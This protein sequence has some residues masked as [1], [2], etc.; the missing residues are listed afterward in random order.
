MPQLYEPIDTLN[1]PYDAFWA[2]SRNVNDPPRTH[3]HYYIELIYVEDGTLQADYDRRRTILHPGDLAVFYPKQIHTLTPDAAHSYRYGVIKFDIGRLTQSSVYTPKLRT[4]LE[5]AK[6]TP[7]ILPVVSADE[8]SPG[9]AGNAF[10]TVI[11]ELGNRNYGYDMIV[12]SVLSSLLV[13]VIRVFKDRGLNVS[14]QHSAPEEASI[15]SVTEYIDA[16]SAEPLRVE[17]L[18][19]RCGMSYSYFA[20]TFRRM[21]GRGCREYIEFVRVCK[22]ED[23]L[24]FTDY[25]LTYISQ[26]TGFSDCSHLI[27]TFKKWKNETPKQFRLRRNSPG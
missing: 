6:N 22:A 21:Y 19:K 25:D 17:D 3:W 26:E 10:H 5:A 24:L 20:R 12:Q 14:V 15:D 1:T 23:L 18:A 11:E 13:S 4:I 2:D 9:Q 16:H 8:L 7:D 27:K